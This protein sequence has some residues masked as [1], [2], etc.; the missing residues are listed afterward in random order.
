MAHSLIGKIKQNAKRLKSETYAL[1]LAIRDPRTP[2]YA[3][4]TAA[5]VVAYALSPIDIIPDFVPILGYLDD[6][7]LL[8][9]GVWISI[10]MIP[11]D[12]MKEA[13]DR[14]ARVTIRGGTESRVATIV[15]VTLWLL[16]AAI[17]AII[18]YRTI[19]PYIGHLL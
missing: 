5:V 16:T 14:A 15:V 18:L 2:W 13:R 9:L 19:R 10:R 17:T 12:V 3:K 1:Y 8:P 4:V 7:I 11:R 6:I